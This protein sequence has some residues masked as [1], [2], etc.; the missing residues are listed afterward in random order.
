VLAAI[1]AGTLAASRLDNLRKLERELAHLERTQD[2]H[3]R[4]EERKKWAAIHK[5]LRQH[6]K[7]RW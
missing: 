3:A 4:R 6:P 7:Q 1:D 2:V 5:S